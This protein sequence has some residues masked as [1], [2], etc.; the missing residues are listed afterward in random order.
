MPWAP[1][2]MRRGIRVR[3]SPW[4]TTTSTEYQSVSYNDRGNETRVELSY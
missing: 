4:F 1:A 3:T 2:R